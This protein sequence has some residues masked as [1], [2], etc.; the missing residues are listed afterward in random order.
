M[1]EHERESLC[2]A[3]VMR[4]EAVGM[5]LNRERAVLLRLVVEDEKERNR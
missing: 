1:T 2:G 5:V 3:C 4:D